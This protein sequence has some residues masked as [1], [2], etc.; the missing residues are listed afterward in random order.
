[1][2]RFVC[3]SILILFQTALLAQQQ[4][5]T[6]DD[7]ITQES[8]SE[9]VFSPDGTMIAWT[10]RRATNKKDRFVTDL[11]LTH[12]DSD[13]Y[14]EI[15]L[16]RTEDS[17]RNPVFS[18]DG[19]TLYFL[20]GRSGG[21]SLW[22][23]N[24]RGGEAYAVDSFPNGISRI[25]RLTDSTLIFRSTEG[26]TRYERELKK[27]K[28]NVVVVEDSVHQTIGRLFSYNLTS[29]QSLRLT[30]NEFPLGSYAAS[31][32]GNWLVTSHS[33]APHSS[34]D[35]QPRPKY[36]LWN[37]VTNTRTEIFQDTLLNPRQF[38]FTQRNAGFYFA[39]TQTSDPEWEGA[40]ISLL[41]YFDLASKTYKKVPLDWT[42]GLSGGISISGEDV[43]VSLANGPTNLMAK[44]KATDDGW[45]QWL[46]DAGDKT[47]NLSLTSI[48]E[49]GE[50]LLLTYSTASHLPEFLLTDLTEETSSLKVNDLSTFTT[51]NKKLA[52]K[53]LAKSEIITWTGAMD[54]EVSGI[55]LYPHDYEEGRRYPLVVAIHGG[56]SGVDRDRW[57][58]RWAYPHQLL[59]QEG[60]FILKPNYHGSSNHG[61]AFVESIKKHYYEYELPDILAGI[62]LLE[63]EGKITKDSLAVIG[64]SNGAILGT[65]LTVEYPGMF[66]AAALG[67]GD[68]NWSS[69]FGTCA[70]GVTFDQ[71]YFGGAPW[72]D[73]DG[74][75]YNPAYI[76]KSP[77]FEMEKVRTP[78]LI[79]H[80]SEDR[81]VPRDQGWEYYRALQQVG[82]APVRFLWY[83][84]QP[85]GLGKLS[86]QRRKVTEEMRWISQYLFG[87]DSQ[88]SEVMAKQSP[89]TARMALADR[90]QNNGIFGIAEK[91]KLLIPE[92]QPLSEDSIEI[93][94]FEVTNAQMLAFRKG[95]V[96]DSPATLNHPASGISYETAVAYCDWLSTKTGETYRLPTL[97]EATAWQGRIIKTAASENTLSYWAGYTLTVDEAEV[98][99]TELPSELVLTMPAGSF[100]ASKIGE[101]MVYDLGGN[102][103]EWVE[104]GRLM[105][106]G[107]LDFVDQ[108]NPNS[109]RNREAAGFR[110]IKE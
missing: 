41:Y 58:D 101:A 83:P 39:A 98:F 92:T 29:K 60:V 70:F 46:I 36:Y 42:N 15:Q 52:N 65:M 24:T 103:A 104:G 9:A 57:S 107:Y 16:T 4:P 54:E 91:K 10:K 44:Y 33:L 96:D 43:L 63:S 95:L 3:F 88:E 25:K 37:L 61:Q 32:D 40:G 45:Q 27:K 84:G 59:A 80:G 55:L 85:H 94:V 7:I 97:A 64:W 47:A 74:L 38:S 1:M 12:L 28:D 99:Q 31:P 35:G 93:G 66:K 108:S 13:P 6:V 22:A 90:A 49:N 77:L 89:L 53:P 75:S 34:S 56:P 20:S 50:K 30:T 102:V 17:D 79:H 68:V 76:L 78:T 105:G 2:N 18:A 82:K 69:D 21:K 86:H 71:S 109:T 48:S 110:V 51:L 23:I 26:K 11:Y 67:A 62:D 106:Y 73:V 5:W 8:I 72:D 81:A 19:N 100:S 14:L 87:K